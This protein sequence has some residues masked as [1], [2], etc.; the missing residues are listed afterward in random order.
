MHLLLFSLLALAIPVANQELQANSISAFLGTWKLNVTK[1]RLGTPP[2]PSRLA[3]TFEALGSDRMKVSYDQAYGDSHSW[4]NYDVGF[5]GQNCPAE[6]F[7]VFGPPQASPKQARFVTVVRVNDHTL[8]WTL[9]T[10]NFDSGADGTLTLTTTVSP[11]G[12]TLTGAGSD[13]S[14]Q[15]FDKQ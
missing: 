11:D 3:V 12:K 15:V 10:H 14:A 13:R 9:R 8:I 2:Q 4:G 1:S 7:P 6:G 5:D